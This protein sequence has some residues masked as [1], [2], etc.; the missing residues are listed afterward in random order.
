MTS[1]DI[2][3]NQAVTIPTLLLSDG[4]PL[5][6]TVRSSNG[7]TMVIDLDERRAA[8]MPARA[9]AH[10]TLEWTEG[11]IE[12][13][14]P[15]R[16]RSSTPRSVVVRVAFDERRE[17]PRFVVDFEMTYQLVDPAQVQAV[18]E[19]V[20][21]RI[22]TLET[23]ES[24]TARLWRSTDEDPHEE[25]RQEIAALREMI[26]DLTARIEDLVSF[27]RGGQD[28]LAQGAQ[29]PLAVTNCSG[30]G[31]GFMSRDALPVEGYLRLHMRLPMTPPVVIDCLGRIVRC[32]P[33][34]SEAAGQPRYDVG[35]SF[36][37]IHENDRESLIHYLFK[38]QRRILRDRKE[39]RE[40]IADPNPAGAPQER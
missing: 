24:Q 15:V 17:S 11:G 3:R 9:D 25:L 37:H 26:G 33:A 16:I 7:E 30:T 35:V 1:V 14:C 20:L 2:A 21:S 31:L 39:A 10:A 40:T 6:G 13:A 28:P 18:A 32:L 12:H 34:Q 22:N 8:H 19:E 27:I 29:K 38:I 5:T 4:K 36:T 23:G